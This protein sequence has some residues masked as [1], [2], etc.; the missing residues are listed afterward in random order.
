MFHH[1]SKCFIMFYHL[2]WGKTWF[3]VPSGN[4]T[5][6]QL[7]Q[8]FA[9]L[10]GKSPSFIQVDQLFL[11][12]IFNSHVKKYQRV[13]PINIPLNHYK[14]PL[15][16]CKSHWTPLS[17]EELGE[18]WKKP[19]W[20]SSLYLPYTIVHSA[21]FFRQ[22]NAF[23]RLGAPSTVDLPFFPIFN[24]EN[25]T[26]SGSRPKLWRGRWAGDKPSALI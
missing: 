23:A 21:T 20:T 10:Y 22:L 12:A 14:V 18:P 19:T 2:S 26:S 4:L 7:V 6:Y 8:D 11:W 3:P 24:A 9:T 13:Y 17:P 5:T 25:P 1:V 16:F 15:F